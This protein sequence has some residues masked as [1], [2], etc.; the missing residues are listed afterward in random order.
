LF[1]EM[2][3]AELRRR[4]PA[5][6][7]QL[8]RRAAAWY[9]ANGQIERAVAHALAGQDTAAAARLVTMYG[10]R[11]FSV[12]LIATVQRWLSALND[13]ALDSY[14]PLAVNAAWIWAVSGE[15]A[16]AYR[17]LRAAEHGRFDGIPPDGSTSMES[18]IARIRA[19]LA[20]YGAEQMRADAHRAVDLEPPA[21]PWHV[22]STTVLGVA[23]MLNGA[24]E[25]ARTALERA[26]V[27][28]REPQPVI[29]AFALAQLSLLTA[30]RGDWPAAE[31][32]AAAS[33]TLVGAL[34]LSDY[35]PSLITYAANAQVAVHR[36]DV[37]G[38]RQCLGN[39][40]R[41]YAV[42]SPEAVPWL[43]AQSAIVLGRILLDLGDIDAARVKATDARRHLTGM[44]N[45][46]ILGDQHQHL[47]D[48]LDRH[49]GQPRP[50]G[51]MTITPAEQ[52]VLQLL[53]THLT[54]GEIGEQLHISRNTAKAHTVSVYR[55]LSA[56]TRAE[57]VRQA[58]SLGLLPP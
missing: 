23:E 18:A 55:K 34:R 25:A 54:L 12:G 9:E 37:P 1:A 19:V 24:T 21:G 45:H 26:D 6:E 35:M 40:M 14:P 41:L 31:A 32:S 20:P 58:R 49:L 39:A 51:G 3:L 47:V 10:Q 46:G 13:G 57:A 48:A 28:G 56:S 36:R 38:A 42:P 17:C 43:A 15:P 33:A 2:L 22:L 52:R 8:H 50:I 44:L 11:T 27:L 5:E 53:P 16:K 30:D 29:A 4:E 7:L